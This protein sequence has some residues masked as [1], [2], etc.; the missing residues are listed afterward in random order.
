MARNR[1][2]EKTKTVVCGRTIDIYKCEAN[3]NIETESR[4]YLRLE[5]LEAGQR[6]SYGWDGQLRGM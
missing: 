1:G 6:N 4:L 5:K 3:V 2:K